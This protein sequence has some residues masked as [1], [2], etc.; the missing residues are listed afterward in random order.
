MNPTGAIGFPPDWNQPPPLVFRN[1][2]PNES[3][4][5]ALVAE[6]S[7]RARFVHGEVVR[8]NSS[9]TNSGNSLP[10]NCIGATNNAG[11]A[12]ITGIVPGRPLVPGEGRYDSIQKFVRG[13]STGN[14]FY[15]KK[16][17]SFILSIEY[18]LRKTIGLVLY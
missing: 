11:Y 7:A 17:A 1:I 10:V 5:S 12:S 2:S 9:D 15:C 13:A 3:N 6:A 4:P 14:F 18:L 16:N 8:F